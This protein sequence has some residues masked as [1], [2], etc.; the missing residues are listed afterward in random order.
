MPG[1]SLKDYI[2]VLPGAGIMTP[3]RFGVIGSAI[4]GPAAGV[5]WQGAAHLYQRAAEAKPSTLKRLPIPQA[6]K[7]HDEASAARYGAR[8]YRE[9]AADARRDAGEQVQEQK[10]IDEAERDKAL[11]E[12][13]YRRQ[14]EGAD[15][16]RE[17]AEKTRKSLEEYRE[18]L[19]KGK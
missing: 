7:P 2:R 11:A 8:W 13:E 1:P 9:H 18:F 6:E 10:K 16:G 12:G 3:L 4:G 15:V 17:N 5:A 19:R 14:V